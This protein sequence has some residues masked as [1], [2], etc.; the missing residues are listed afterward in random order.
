VRT[1]HTCQA[2]GTWSAISQTDTCTAA[3]ATP[4]NLVASVVSNGIQL[5]WSIVPG[6][7][8]YRIYRNNDT[9]GVYY[10]LP[11]GSSTTYV[12]TAVANG[13][14]YTYA[15]AAQNSSSV[16]V[17][18]SAPSG[19][20]SKTYTSGQTG[21]ST[22]TGFSVARIAGGL[23][24]TWN[25]VSGADSYL[26][27]RFDNRPNPFLAAVGAVTSFNDTTYSS[28]G[29]ISGISYCYTVAAQ[30]GSNAS[31]QTSMMCALA[32]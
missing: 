17:V 26:I 12:D 5:T 9:S 31:P 27:Y 21:V 32:P 7:T 11:G 29:L 1:W 22:P 30:Q 14:T 3:L 4:S 20:V 19:W 18:V 28:Q 15:V 6:A 24:L 10:T 13:Q 25:A 2:D 8:A 16:P 23:R